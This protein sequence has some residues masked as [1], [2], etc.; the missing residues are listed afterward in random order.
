VLR[1]ARRKMRRA[2]WDITAAAGT[3]GGR[4]QDRL[5]EPELKALVDERG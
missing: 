1:S 5:T 4:R 2:N 3:R